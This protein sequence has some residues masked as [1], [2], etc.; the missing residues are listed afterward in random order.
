MLPVHALISVWGAL[1]VVF[2]G[3]VVVV[4]MVDSVSWESTVESSLW[5]TLR[6]RLLDQAIAFCVSAQEA[7][8]AAL[9]NISFNLICAFPQ[10]SD[11]KV[12]TSDLTILQN[13]N[14]IVPIKNIP[15]NLHDEPINQFELREQMFRL[16]GPFS[17][18]QHRWLPRK[19]SIEK[20]NLNVS[21]IE[22]ILGFKNSS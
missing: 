20:C 3:A 18:Q 17:T 19:K 13:H 8:L 5:L 2:G 14:V 15:H 4:A 7:N 11:H 10:S 9:S 12:E 6:S 1:V 16:H 21:S 22:H